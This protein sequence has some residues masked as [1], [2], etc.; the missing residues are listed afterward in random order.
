MYVVLIVLR[1]GLFIT[2]SLGYLISI[3]SLIEVTLLLIF[4]C[5]FQFP[6]LFWYCDLT[7]STG[8]LHCPAR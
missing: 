1:F 4:Y 6:A 7:F 3:A 5:L 8:A 2:R